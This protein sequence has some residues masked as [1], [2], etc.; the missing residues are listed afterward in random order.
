MGR[1]TAHRRHEMTR[2]AAT[3]SVAGAAALLIVLAALR[4]ELRSIDPAALGADILNVPRDR[5]SIAAALTA[6]NYVTLTGY[7]FVAFAYLGKQLAR[8]RVMLTSFLAYAISNNLSLAM[9]SGATV[10]YRFYSRW[11]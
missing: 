5:L 6:L 3:A 8:W 7:D 11:A 10:R 9:L 2:S 1:S 4:I